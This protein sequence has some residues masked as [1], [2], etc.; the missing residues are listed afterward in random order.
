MRVVA[1]HAGE[2]AVDDGRHA[3]DGERGFRD[4]GRDD[5]LARVVA[6]HGP[7]LRIRRQLAVQRQHQAIA[8]RLF[9]LHRLHRPA[10]LV[11]AG[12]E[13]QQ[14]ARRPRRHPRARARRHLP[15]RLAVEVDALGQVLDADREHATLRREHLARRE[16]IPEFAGI[17]GGRHDNEL[18]VGPD[19]LLDLQRP[20]EAD[21]AV[22]VPLMKLVEDNRAHSAQHWLVR[23]LPQQDALG[24][25]AD[26][27]GLRH[28]RVEPDLVTD[29]LPQR[30]ADLL[31][32]AFRQQPGREPPRLQ[33][34]HLP[35][36]QQSV[37]EKHLRQLRG[38]A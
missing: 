38:F 8:Q 9:V 28:A 18:Q 33:Y 17:E 12:H 23:H 26:A 31:G 16:V 13:N 10:D 14:V 29:R 1:R 15:H 20:R 5:D 24:D 37:P 21:V 30:R 32:H 34:D 35:F 22:E 7:I 19:R 3:V 36:A 27:R 25:E 2:A 4:I 11:G 6:R